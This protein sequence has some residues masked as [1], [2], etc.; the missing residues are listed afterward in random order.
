MISALATIEI[1]KPT[2]FTR[3]VSGETQ[4]VRSRYQNTD[5]GTYNFPVTDSCERSA[6]VMADDYVKLQFKLLH[7]IPFDAFSYIWYDG[8]LFFLKEDYRPT[9]KGSHFEYQ[10]KFVSVANMLDKS[11][12]L[13]YLTS[14]QTDPEP[15]INMN[16]TLEDMAAI[17]MGAIGGAASR[18]TASR[19][20][21]S[22]P[23]FYVYTLQHLTLADDILQNT[24]LETF[25]F[26]GQNIADVLTQLCN[27]YQT[28]WWISQESLYSTKLHLCRCEKGDT[29]PLSDT[30]KQTTNKLKPY[31]SRGLLSCEYSQEWS[32][33]PQ[34]LIP[35]GS[36][37][38]ITRQQAL[39]NV[40]GNDMYVSYGKQL[41][42]APNTTYNVKDR[43]GNTVQVT[44]NA[45]GA[46]VNTNKTGIET[47]KNFDDIYPRCHFRV[48]GLRQEG[49]PE[50]PIYT[51]TAGALKADGTTVMTYAEMVSEGLLPLQIE[52]NETLSVR[53]ESGYLN[54]REFEV[55]HDIK[56]ETVDINGTP[57][58]IMR[59]LLTI[60]PEE[61]GDDGVSLPFGN[62]VPRPVSGTYEGD[63]FAIFHMV[64]PTAYVN[65]ARE[66]L[67]QAAYDELLA[68]EDTRPEVKCKTDPDVFRNETITLGQRVAVYSELF[69]TITY[70]QAG[71][72]AQ[73][74]GGLFASR[75]T[76]FQHSL[77]KPTTIEFKLA[78]ACVEGRLA[79]IEAVIADRTSDIRGLEQRSLNL[80]RRGWHD[81]AEMKDMLETLAAEMMLVGVE[82]N[83][84]GFTMAIESVGAEVAVN[85]VKY[86]DHLHISAGYIQHTQEPYIKYTNQGKWEV[87][88]ADLTTDIN[89]EALD[90]TKPYYLYAYCPAAGTTATMYLSL[91]ALDNADPST[92]PAGTGEDYLLLGILSSEFLDD[93][94]TPNTSYRVFNR[95]NGYTQITGGTITTEQIQ[96][97]TRSLI[98]DFASNPP[99][100]IAKNGAQIIGKITFLSS[101]GTK[102]DLA[103]KIGTM[104][105]E[106]STAKQN[107][108][109]AVNKANNI[110]NDGIIS[111]GTEKAT[112]KKEWQEIAGDNM[113]GTT[114]GSYKKALAQA[115][116]YDITVANNS[117][118]KTAYAA[119]EDAMKT[120]IGYSNSA[121]TGSNMQNDTYL[122]G[123]T[124]PEGASTLNKTRDQ[125]AALW[126]AYYDAEIALLNDV[127]DVIDTREIGGENLYTKADPL[128]IG[129][130][131][132]NITLETGKKYI[133]TVVSK[134]GSACP[135]AA[136]ENY[137]GGNIT[138]GTLG[139][140]IANESNLVLKTTGHGGTLKLGIQGSSSQSVTLTGIM[141]QQGE[142]PTTYQ[143]SY[144]FL[145]EAFE[146]DAT[147]LTTSIDGGLIVS[148]LIKLINQLNVVT[149]GISGLHGDN[150][151]LWGGAT[152]AEALNAANTDYYKSGTSGDRI[153][154]L[155][156][157]DGTGKIGILRIGTDQVEI[158]IPSKGK[159]IFNVT[160][161]ISIKDISDALKV[162]FTP[163]SVQSF[164][165]SAGSGGKQVGHSVFDV[166][167]LSAGNTLGKRSYVAA[168]NVSSL[169]GGVFT[170]SQGQ[171][172]TI[173]K[174]QNKL[175]L[176][177]TF[178]GSIGATANVPQMDLIFRIQKVGGG[179]PA[180]DKTLNLLL[181]SSYVY[182]S[183]I[184]TQT[185]TWTNLPVGEYKLCAQIG[186]INPSISAQVTFYNFNIQTELLYDN[187]D[188]KTV[189]G[190]DG[191]VSVWSNR[192]RFVV[193]NTASEQLIYAVGLPTSDPHEQG[194][195]YALES[196]YIIRVSAG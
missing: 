150:I 78:S 23:L 16:G 172:F 122:S 90:A 68:I 10:M 182:G 152:Y 22:F 8:Q 92:L 13:R 173:T 1:Y 36:E 85:N 3:V 42:L 195:L 184:S 30:Y 27:T 86:F 113:L 168:T 145:A 187:I 89:G 149:A 102:T 64:M 18:L 82:K 69:G 58:T 174:A 131:E 181:N 108:T 160:D 135:V 80:S 154:T 35:Y 47:I 55:R 91:A 140:W 97:P 6:T 115:A 101:D 189:I 186:A 77:T 161:G 59:W 177:C 75:V 98:I 37:R 107:A 100:I 138:I 190:T 9:D 167:P 50:H 61:G 116:A 126:R 63:M 65:R 104:D 151:F 170:E 144:K 21:G 146:H 62:F 117:A 39:E 28:E 129:Y 5:D 123:T 137:G 43:E 194:Q 73:D 157:D 139:G 57:T 156:K 171:T 26:S 159:I 88:A 40:N 183:N 112:I 178:G 72:I 153:T 53:F 56:E 111:G 12:A 51:M 32:N 52:P 93:L 136:Y 166:G 114:D 119:L 176:K 175:T 49:T 165:D 141:V 132:T 11:L 48:I 41:R 44:T 81:A 25:S 38:N 46:F 133:I 185:Y 192:R 15:E 169:T 155:V 17:V 109:D 191:I 143:N 94:P 79:S 34:I 31:Q 14:V 95:S 196:D 33:V 71:D 180:S 128:T 163:Q 106:I 99:R 103:T 142:K 66:E 19:P 124:P 110:A 4:I 120:I 7:Q 188:P 121:W 96:D 179:F 20:V 148:A 83:Q 193:K 24:A 147:K 118:I 74:S 54:G 84:F 2:Y 134:S 76:S 164:I 127:S 45:L 158:V 130:L 162:L 60:V 70:D 67:A 105:G 125:F 87:N 29:L